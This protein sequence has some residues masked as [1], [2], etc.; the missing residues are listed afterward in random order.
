MKQLG[1]DLI[2]WRRRLER[3]FSCQHAGRDEDARQD[4][5]AEVAVVADAVAHDAE[6]VLRP[7]EPKTTFSQQLLESYSCK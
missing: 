4:D 7:N 1:P 6:S 3:V 2:S 5:V